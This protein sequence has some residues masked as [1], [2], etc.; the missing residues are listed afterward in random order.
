MRS[1]PVPR[2]IRS[3]GA[4]ARRLGVLLLVA[5]LP[6]SA[7]LGVHAAPLRDRLELFLELVR[8]RLTP[9]DREETEQVREAIRDVYAIL[10]EEILENLN[11]E[12]P[13]A[14][15]AFIQERLEGFTERWGWGRF[16]I[17]RPKALPSQF[18]ASIQLTPN[19]G[20]SSIRAYARQGGRYTLAHVVQRDAVPIVAE[21]PAARSGVSHV[22]VGWVGPPSGRG[23]SPLLLELVRLDGQ[24]GRSVWS[25]QS[26]FPSGLHVLEFQMEPDG[27]SIRYPGQYPGRK[28]GCEGETDHGDRYRYDS[29]REVLQLGARTVMNGWHQEFHQKALRPLLDA[30]NSGNE[31]MLRS[32]VPS[33]ALRQQLPPGLTALPVC[34][35]A[36]PQSAPAEIRVSVE[37]SGTQ[38]VPMQLTLL[39]RKSQRGWL[40]SDVKREE[41]PSSLSSPQ[42]GEG[43]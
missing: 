22:L 42:R 18:V 37:A 23:T 11:S 32:L 14:S 40:L 41:S 19:G 20:G 9:P 36:T 10:D 17:W 38:Q 27:F 24:G 29:T 35:D 34:D 13:F 2:P 30:L 5:S 31:P 8:S 39:F 26:L 7:T 21:M 12:G 3:A 16:V 1:L 6:L 33:G 15:E 28:P 25:S 4:L 43:G